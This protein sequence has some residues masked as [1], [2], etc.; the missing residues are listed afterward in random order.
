MT[1]TIIPAHEVRE[2]EPCEWHESEEDA[3]AGLAWLEDGHR[4]VFAV[5]ATARPKH[6]T[7]AIVDRPAPSLPSDAP[8][9]DARE[10]PI[11]D[12]KAARAWAEWVTVPVGLDA[13]H[14][15]GGLK[16]LARVILACCPASLGAAIRALPDATPPAAV[17]EGADP[18]YRI[19]VD[20]VISQLTELLGTVGIT[21]DWTLRDIATPKR[22]IVA[23]ACVNAAPV[24]LDEIERLR[25]D[26]AERVRS[27]MLGAV[28]KH[29]LRDLV[30][31]LEDLAFARGR[32]EALGANPK[33]LR[34]AND[35][36]KAALLAAIADI[37]AALTTPTS[38]TTPA[39]THGETEA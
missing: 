31:D 28:D 2:G 30:D 17:R 4:D 6:A 24:L 35:T 27:V 34:A 20:E 15:P 33:P 19:G 37:R 10:E 5:A 14:M 18:R 9:V 29:R 1:L 7:H 13:P 39:T 26:V 8:G 22:R 16:A 3:D 23:A 38:G 11:L 12:I 25:A 21:G 36:A 32:G